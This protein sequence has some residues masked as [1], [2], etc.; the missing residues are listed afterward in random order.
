MSRK[1]ILTFENNEAKEIERALR[2]K[3]NCLSSLEA[4]CVRVVL[5]EVREYIEM[6]RHGSTDTVASNQRTL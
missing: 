5:Q 2:K 4:L 6:E 1:V 3:Y